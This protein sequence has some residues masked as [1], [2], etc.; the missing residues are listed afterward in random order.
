MTADLHAHGGAIPASTTPGAAR[1]RTARVIGAGSVGLAILSAVAAI[2]FGAPDIDSAG[3]YGLMQASFAVSGLLVVN[4]VPDNR[5]GW[6][7]LL[8]GLS[9][10][11]SMA[12][13]TL[14]GILLPVTGPI[15]PVTL[16]AW[17]AEP[18]IQVAFSLA[19]GF[20]PLLFPT[21]TLPSPRWWVAVAFVVGLSIVTVGTAAFL[22]GPLSPAYPVV[23]PFGIPWVGEVSETANLLQGILIV[24]VLPV[25]A[26]SQVSRFRRGT[27]VVRQQVKWFAAASGLSVTLIAA[28]VLAPGEAIAN[29]IWGL[30]VLS[31]PLLPAAIGLAI[32]RYRLY[33]IDRIVSRTLG[34]ALVS[35][36]I[37]G[38]FAI[39]ALTI[40]TA[41]AGMAQ[42]QTVA[43]AGSTLLAA[44]AFQPIRRRVQRLV[45][46]RFDRARYD[47]ERVADQ[48]RE[49]LRDRVDP[50]GIE[51]EFAR[52]VGEALRP[53]SAAVW[54]RHGAH[55]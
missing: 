55:R 47:G 13:S 43:V 50:A 29:A 51:T 16:L 34:W 2:A 21:G 22:P 49:R 53:G 28:A 37:A 10:A 15:A 24:V 4:R 44:S 27:V 1:R 31:V 46:R 12:G 20:L 14:P 23:N 52:T 54:V 35:G 19:V 17:L 11:I 36:A 33:D 9:L 30:A 42:G 6:I 48:F 18:A 5:V 41:L 39:A 26:A 8:V 32:L 7:L 40:G 25:C 3:I 45:D 38:L